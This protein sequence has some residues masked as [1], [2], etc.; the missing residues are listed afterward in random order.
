MNQKL[1][2]TKDSIEDSV[3]KVTLN[4]KSLA[5]IGCIQALY[6]HET[7]GEFTAEHL[8]DQIRTYYRSSKRI[9][10]DFEMDQKLYLKA[11]I[12]DDLLSSLV[13]YS[14]W[15]IILIDDLISKHLFEPWAVE[16][17]HPLLRSIIRAAVCELKFFPATS[18]KI[19][20]NDFVNIATEMLSNEGEI[21]FVN[22]ILDKI[23]RH[24]SE[25]SCAKPIDSAQTN[26]EPIDSEEPHA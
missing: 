1:S 16:K 21:N 17:L 9:K 6:I 20:I 10:E 18:Y 23:Y 4:S 5:R 22:A 12:D 26:V 24:L 13:S 25:Q 7:V 2:D 19:V 8:I 3:E 14:M 11:I 15:S